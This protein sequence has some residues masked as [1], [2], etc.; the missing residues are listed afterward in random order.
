MTYQIGA[1]FATLVN[2]NTVFFSDT[3]SRVPLNPKS[4]PVPGGDEYQ[5]MDGIKR[6]RG[7]KRSKWKLDNVLIASYEMAVAILCSTAGTGTVARN[8]GDPTQLDGTATA[9]TTE[10]S[11]NDTI[12]AHLGSGVYELMVVALIHDATTLHVTSAISNALA[13]ATFRYRPQST[14]SGNC[15]VTTNVVTKGGV[16][17]DTSFSAVAICQ[18][19]S[20]IERWGKRYQP[21]EIEYILKSLVTS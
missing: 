3:S 6:W 17:V 4:T 9:F 14:Y 19:P 5:S 16:N 2:A 12:I 15:Y 1:S 8:G 13:G 18:D 10:L 7:Y 11:V 21:L 20:K